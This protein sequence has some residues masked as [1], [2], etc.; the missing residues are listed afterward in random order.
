MTG[1]MSSA[2]SS[3]DSV[4]QQTSESVS[5]C[6]NSVYASY[7]RG[8]QRVKLYQAVQ[9]WETVVSL[10]IDGLISLSPMTLPRASGLGSLRLDGAGSATILTDY[11]KDRP[12][13]APMWRE[14]ACSGSPMTNRFTLPLSYRAGLS[15][16]CQWP[17]Q[18]AHRQIGRMVELRTE[19][20]IGSATR[21]AP[22]GVTVAD[23]LREA[24]PTQSMEVGEI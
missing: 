2:H 15:V 19:F 12:G 16:Y 18:E 21:R 11:A 10:T 7:V 3:W 24:V 1:Q 20:P 17:L 4:Y 5:P 14:A 6:W 23:L 13:H 22:A 8:L 9:N